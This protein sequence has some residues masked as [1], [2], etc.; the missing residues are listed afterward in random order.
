M[1]RTLESAEAAG[2]G[3]NDRFS[4]SHAGLSDRSEQVSGR[5]Y[6]WYGRFGITGE[7]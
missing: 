5:K 3:T 1:D 6:G 4:T 2:L 7:S